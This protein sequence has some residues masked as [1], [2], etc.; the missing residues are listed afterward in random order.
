[1][2]FIFHNIVVKINQ[3][4]AK[5]FRIELIPFCTIP[6]VVNKKTEVGAISKFSFN[7]TIHLQLS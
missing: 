1:M 7:N 3:L 5:D 6:I 4:D 2:C